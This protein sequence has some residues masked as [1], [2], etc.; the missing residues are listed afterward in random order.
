MPQSPQIRYDKQRPKVTP[1]HMPIGDVRA[2][3]GITLD[4]LADR[5]HETSGLKVTR[6]SLSAI[7]NGHRGASAELLTAIALAFGVRNEA[8]TTNYD[9]RAR[10]A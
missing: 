9:P 6:A 1:P 10:A 4:Q 5:I 2:A 7:E 3:V 8:V